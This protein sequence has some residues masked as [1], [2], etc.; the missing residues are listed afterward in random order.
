[1]NKYLLHEISFIL[2]KFDGSIFTKFDVFIVPFN[3]E[4]KFI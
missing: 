4:P 3:C 1:M 2:Y